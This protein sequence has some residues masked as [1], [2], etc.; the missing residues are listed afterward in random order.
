[1]KF[2]IADNLI[3]NYALDKAEGR[4]LPIEE[5]VRKFS[6]KLLEISRSFL[7]IVENIIPELLSEYG[8]MVE[9]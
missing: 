5:K 8:L 4:D 2:I 7:D 9:D 6:E 3:I 1:M